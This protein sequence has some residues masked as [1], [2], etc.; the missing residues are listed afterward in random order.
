MPSSACT[1]SLE[2]GAEAAPAW[3]SIPNLDENFLSTRGFRAGYRYG[4]T[5]AKYVGSFRAL[6]RLSV[7]GADQSSASPIS[8][9]PLSISKV[10]PPRKRSQVDHRAISDLILNCSDSESRGNTAILARGAGKPAFVRQRKTTTPGKTELLKMLL[11]IIP[12]GQPGAD[13]AGPDFAIDTDLE[14]G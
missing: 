14:Q 13:R 7:A 1:T 9:A 3:R 11:K 5:A 4:A 10:P 8:P 12:G 6:P 2:C